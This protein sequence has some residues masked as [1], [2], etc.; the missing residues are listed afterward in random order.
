MLAVRPFLVLAHRFSR[1]GLIT[2]PPA[3]ERTRLAMLT[4]WSVVTARSDHLVAQLLCDRRS[5]PFKCCRLGSRRSAPGVLCSLLARCWCMAWPR[6]PDSSTAAE[7]PSIR[8]ATPSEGLLRGGSR[9]LVFCPVTHLSSVQPF[10][11]VCEVQLQPVL[12][13]N[14]H[15]DAFFFIRPINWGT[16]GEVGVAVACIAP[17]SS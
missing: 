12:R 11:W 4:W 16:P 7:T 14:V 5:C 2:S 15:V 13:R 1:G 17:P 10:Q 8:P 9:F 3:R 6:V